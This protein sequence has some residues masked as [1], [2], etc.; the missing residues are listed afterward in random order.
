MVGPSTKK[1]RTFPLLNGG[2]P[3]STS[4]GKRNVGLKS[5]V[6][7]LR[8]RFSITG[9]VAEIV[10]A[11]V[12]LIAPPVISRGAVIVQSRS[13]RTFL[14]A[15]TLTAVFSFSVRKRRTTLGSEIAK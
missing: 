5:P 8:K 13:S 7:L 11:L 1:S 2:S 14:S 3:F 12:K 6:E 9:F 10:T 4:V 15:T